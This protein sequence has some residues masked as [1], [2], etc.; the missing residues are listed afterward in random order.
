MVEDNELWIY[1]EFIGWRVLEIFYYVPLVATRSGNKYIIYWQY[2]KL[3]P[4]HEIGQHQVNGRR[5]APKG[6]VIIIIIAPREDD[7]WWEKL[8]EWNEWRDL[9][10]L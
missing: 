9:E 2:T 3:R 6:V 4:F 7:K 1:I 10:C 5:L 8:W